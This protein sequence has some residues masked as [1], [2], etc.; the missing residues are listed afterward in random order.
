ML[1]PAWNREHI[2]DVQIDVPETLSIE[3]RAAFYDATGAYR[4]M[5][6]THLFQAMAFVA[7]E[8]PVSLSAGPLREEK[9]KVFQT[10]KPLDVRHVVRGQYQGYRSEPGV[11]AGSQTDTMV[12]N[13]GRRQHPLKLSAGV[14]ADL[15]EHL[16]QVPFDCAWTDEQSRSDLRIRQPLTGEPRDL[17]LMGR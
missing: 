1:E 12:A 6:V 5:I 17:R 8:P 14:D 10:V 2:S 16:V 3:G 13:S 7:M 4:D 9:L 15:F 11:P